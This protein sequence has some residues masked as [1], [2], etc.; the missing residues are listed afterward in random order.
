MASAEALDE[1]RIEKAKVRDLSAVA[2]ECRVAFCDGRDAMIWQASF[3]HPAQW[4]KH[5]RTMYR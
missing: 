2:A 4:P 3:Q 1:S 5:V